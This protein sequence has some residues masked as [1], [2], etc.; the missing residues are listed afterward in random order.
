[1]LSKM[2]QKIQDLAKP[3]SFT[4]N[5]RTFFDGAY[6][7]LRP[8]IPGAISINNLSGIVDFVNQIKDVEGW[9]NMFIHIS[10]YNEVNLYRGR[11]GEMNKR[12]LL[13]RARCRESEFSFN[14]MMGRE[15]FIIS[16]YSMFEKNEDRQEL[17]QMVSGVKIDENTT[18]T[19]D[20]NGQTLMSKT[21]MSSQMQDIKQKPLYTLVPFRTFDQVAQPASLFNFRW[22]KGRDGK[23]L[24]CAIYGADGSAWKQTAIESIAQYFRDALTIPVIA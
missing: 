23:S 13:A 10:D 21:G 3:Q 8:T 17:L 2:I 9:N 12:E 20:G 6:E 16:M 4:L 11:S 7:E 5:E 24:N 14:Q 22:E 18:L 19:D 1:M 15:Q